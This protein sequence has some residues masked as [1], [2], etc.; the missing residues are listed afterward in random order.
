MINSLNSIPQWS[1]TILI[2]DWTNSEKTNEVVSLLLGNKIHRLFSGKQ[3]GTRYIK[4]DDV[5]LIGHHLKEPKY[6][7]LKSAFKII[8][9]GPDKFRENVIFRTMKPNKI[10]NLEEFSPE[11]GTVCIF[12]DLC[13]DSKKIQEKI[14]KT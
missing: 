14:S 10:P 4:C 9:N 7:Y 13:A 1:F 11:R 3:E 12:K 8:A 6:Q 2:S 5:V